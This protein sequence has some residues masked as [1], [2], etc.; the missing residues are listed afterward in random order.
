MLSLK[1]LYNSPLSTL[2]KGW[3]KVRKKEDQVRPASE[4]PSLETDPLKKEYVE[5]IPEAQTF[6]GVLLQGYL[7]PSTILEG[8][9]EMEIR[10]DDVFIITYPKSATAVLAISMLREPHAKGAQHV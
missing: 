7:V 6:R 5:C 9:D 1:L 3:R 2:V 10:E 4:D 8:L